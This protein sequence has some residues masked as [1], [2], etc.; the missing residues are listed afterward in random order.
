MRNSCST[1][2]AVTILPGGK[3]ARARQGSGRFHESHVSL[4][5]Q[6][7]LTTDGLWAWLGGSPRPQ[8]A[9]RFI[10]HHLLAG[11]AGQPPAQLHP[12]PSTG[13]AMIG[14]RCISLACLCAAPV[15]TA[16][17][18]QPSVPTPALAHSTHSRFT[19][20]A[21]SSLG[22]LIQGGGTGEAAVAQHPA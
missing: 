10:P 19:Q 9:S 1:A 20:A 8:T 12:P 14:P 15:Q 13:L 4:L 11:T 16:N 22:L 5:S 2:S 21:W 6:S 3:R 7:R 17:E 18:T